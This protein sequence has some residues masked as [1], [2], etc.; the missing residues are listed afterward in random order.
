MK[1][2]IRK[3]AGFRYIHLYF[4]FDVKYDLRR[5]TRLVDGGN[6]TS[7]SIE[8][9]YSGVVS[10]ESVRI[11]LLLA[12]ANNLEV[13]ATDV[14]NA[15][16]YGTTKEKLYTFAGPCKAY[17][18]VWIRDKDTHYEYINVYIDD[19]IIISK[20]PMAVT[21]EL[22]DIANYTLK[23]V[24]VPEYYLGGDIKREKGKDGRKH[25]TIS[26]KTYIRNVC[27]KIEK[28]MDVQLKNYHSPLEGGYHPELDTSPFLSPDMIT[29]YRMLERDTFK[30]CFAFSDIS[31]T[32]TK[33]QFDS[34]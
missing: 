18:D 31:N 21:R 13:L 10:I 14:G 1:R 28:L 9:I 4:V 22:K 3:L 34:T 27:K 11:A 25:T 7:P 8:D 16:L 12:D 23:G 32:M 24:G 26:A 20:D 29:R 5:K 15:F 2:G 19:L 17:P 6:T 30:P 33:P